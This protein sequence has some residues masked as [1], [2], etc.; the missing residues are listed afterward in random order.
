MKLIKIPSAAE[1]RKTLVKRIG[2]MVL[3]VAVVGAGV[4]WWLLRD[5]QNRGNQA[6]PGRFE[7]QSEEADGA[8]ARYE[9]RAQQAKDAPKDSLSPDDNYARLM[10]DGADLTIMGRYAEAIAAYEEAGSTGVALNQGYYFAL[11]QAYEAAAQYE[12]AATAYKKSYSLAS[13]ELTDPE[14]RGNV[15]A[16]I[17]EAIGRVEKA[18]E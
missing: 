11:G 18:G 1:Q 14:V 16:Q 2:L 15:L 4:A 10:E 7:I 5:S 12:H 6:E 3:V 8:K 13:K 17:E 9:A